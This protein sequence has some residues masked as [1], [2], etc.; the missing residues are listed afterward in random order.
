MDKLTSN[1]KKKYVDEIQEGETT[2]RRQGKG[3]IDKSWQEW[4]EFD[5]FKDERG[6]T[7]VEK[8]PSYKKEEGADEIEEGKSVTRRKNE[9]KTNKL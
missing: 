6:Y 1:K 9:G 8:S 7:D 4:G 2:A 3:K 5:K